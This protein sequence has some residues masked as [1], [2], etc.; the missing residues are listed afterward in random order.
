M[1]HTLWRESALF[2]HPGVFQYA[3][4]TWY[5]SV[6]AF[7][8]CGN[9]AAMAGIKRTTSSFAAQH[10][11]HWALWQADKLENSS[12]M[13]KRNIEGKLCFLMHAR[14]ISNAHQFPRLV[15][16]MISAKAYWLPRSKKK[17]VKTTFIR[18]KLKLN[19]K[20]FILGVLHV[21]A[22]IYLRG[23]L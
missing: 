23:T 16:G 5:I 19:L 18:H 10:H 8:L 21:K 20:N 1:K 2:W 11:S 4:H 13:E 6:F 7:H 9:G 3:P 15:H 14:K 17:E 12:V 22:K